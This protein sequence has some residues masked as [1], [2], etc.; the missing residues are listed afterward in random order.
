MEELEAIKPIFKWMLVK[1][2]VEEKGVQ[3]FVLNSFKDSYIAI[4][5]KISNE[6]I[7]KD[8]YYTVST[9]LYAEDLTTEEVQTPKINKMT[10]FIDN[11][12]EKKVVKKTVFTKVVNLDS[13]V[14]ATL[15]PNDF[16]NVE[17]IGKSNLYG[18]IFKA[19]S[20]DAN[21][22]TLYFGEKG[23]EFNK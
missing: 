19:W 15:K 18:D 8:T 10:N 2:S 1:D 14:N 17:F 13:V 6:E 12:T 4:D 21:K 11:T 9:W 20:Y 23:D 5:N 16:I 3:R 22:F 7:N